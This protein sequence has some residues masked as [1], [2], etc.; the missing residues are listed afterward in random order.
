LKVP[1]PKADDKVGARLAMDRAVGVLARVPE[2]G[3]VKTRLIP[4]LGPEGAAWLHAALVFDTLDKVRKTSGPM[5]RYLFL[6]AGNAAAAQQ[7]KRSASGFKIFKQ[8]GADLGARLGHAFRTLLSKHAAALVI[9][10]DSPL[11]PRKVLRR[12]FMQLL[13]F[14]SVMGPCPDGGF[15]LIGLRWEEAVKEAKIFDG[16]RWGTKHAYQDILRNLLRRGFSFSDLPE[17]PAV[18]RPADL[19][20]LRTALEGLRRGRRLAPATWAFLEQHPEKKLRLA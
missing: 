8:E 13:Y 19:P 9:G 18:D 14:D 20:P 16:V 5:A 11:V 10:T 6:T 12:A 1:K 7:V 15:Y 3:R 2:P 4:F 17:Y